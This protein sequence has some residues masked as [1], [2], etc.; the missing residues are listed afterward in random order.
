M[1]SAS[2]ACGYIERFEELLDFEV[3]VGYLLKGHFPCLFK[4]LHVAV[5]SDV[6]R[7]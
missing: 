5:F 2:N 1:V 4:L 7:V 6:I 3:C